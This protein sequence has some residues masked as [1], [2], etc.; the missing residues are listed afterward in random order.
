MDICIWPINKAFISFLKQV[1]VV[2]D[3]KDESKTFVNRFICVSV[4][5]P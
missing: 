3:L 1:P 2:Y 4:C 5:S